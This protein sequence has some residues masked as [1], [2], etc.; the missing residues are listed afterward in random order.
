MNSMQYTQDYMLWHKQQRR[1]MNSPQNQNYENY[2]LLVMQCIQT[3][4]TK[5]G[6]T[7]D[8]LKDFL[9]LLREAYITKRFLI[10]YWTLP[11]RLEEFVLP[12][13][14]GLDWTAPDWLQP[15]LEDPT[16]GRR[17]YKSDILIRSD[18]RQSNTTLIRTRV[19][20]TTGLAEKY[21][22]QLQK[23]EDPFDDVYHDVWRIFFTPAPAVR[24]LIETEFNQ[25]GLVPGCYAAAHLRA[26]YGRITSREDSQTIEWTQNAINCATQ[27]Y[28][29][30]P[31]IFFASD[32][33]FATTAAIE[34]GNQK[35]LH[36]VARHHTLFPLH[37]DSAENILERKPS[38]FYD[39]WVDL[40]LMGMSR[41][42]TVSFGFFCLGLVNLW[43]V[44][45]CLFSPTRLTCTTDDFVCFEI[46]Q[47]NRGGFGHWGLLI[48][49]NA[50]CVINQ[51]TSSQGIGNRCDWN[52]FVASQVPNPKRS[53]APLFSEP[54]DVNF[55]QPRTDVIDRNNN[56]IVSRKLKEL[57][58]GPWM[59]NYVK[60][61]EEMKNNTEAA[62]SAE[63]MRISQSWTKDDKLSLINS[64]SSKSVISSKPQVI[65]SVSSLPTWMADYFEW[66]KE[67]RQSINGKNWNCTKYMI[68][69][70]YTTDIKCGGL[71][72]RLKPLPSILLNA[73]ITN[74]LLF[75]MWDRPKPLENWFKPPNDGIDWRLPKWLKQKLWKSRKWRSGQLNDMVKRLDRWPNETALWLTIQTPDGGEGYFANHSRS[76][77]TYADVFHTLFRSFFTPVSRLQTAIDEQMQTHGLVPGEYAS[78]HFRCM[79]GNRKWRDPLDTINITVNGINCASNLFPGAPVYFASDVRFAVDVATEYGT[80]NAIQIATLDNNGTPSHFD[81][82]DGWQTRGVSYYDDTFL[83]LLML[84]DSKC[85]AYSNGGYG[86]FGSLLSHDATCIDRFFKSR[87]MVKYFK[88]MYADGSMKRLQLPHI[89]IP[90]Q[91]KI[92]PDE[93]SSKVNNNLQAFTLLS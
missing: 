89:E 71:A 75:I 87:K 49:Y 6:G 93:A 35:N 62:N 74:R 68:M 44:I 32:Y 48:G 13:K 70:C 41:C 84:A 59:G 88:W 28:P 53:G 33:T 86:L 56:K 1:I 79:Y 8:R 36:V 85:V 76:E 22:P 64:N 54:M 38:E 31:S 60:Y 69:S 37:L 23:G 92:I 57:Q 4:D 45:S 15:I 34:Y 81:K 29:S 9:F 25:M 73:A 83:D 2:R 58:P 16:I 10:I 67:T 7:A 47:H 39:T 63:D 43:T 46:T 20:S 65:S 14:G 26:L 40:Y 61:H 80:Q 17:I 72:D 91:L 51:R 42:V 90:D 50:S 82:D 3:Y 11:C 5:C 12:P 66:H 24:T 77:S 30:T 78:A 27:L 19:Q 18:I 21:D 52:D 55:P